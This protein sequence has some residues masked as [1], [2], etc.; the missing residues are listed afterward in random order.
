MSKGKVVCGSWPRQWTLTVIILCAIV[1][2]AI[3][4]ACAQ[5]AP[6][7]RVGITTYTTLWSLEGHGSKAPY[8]VI[9]MADRANTPSYGSLRIAEDQAT[10]PSPAN[11]ITRQGGP[12]ASANRTEKIESGPLVL[13][14]LLQPSAGV[15]GLADFRTDP[16]QTIPRS[17][18][19]ARA[20]VYSLLDDGPALGSFPYGYQANYL[21]SKQRL[22]NNESFTDEVVQAPRPLFELN[23]GSWRLPVMLSGAA[24]S[25]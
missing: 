22:A 10:N 7:T 9:G 8:L 16:R 3:G 11:T 2:W 6:P 20:K 25:R 12:A 18:D 4:G 1:W 21:P 17:P 15:R 23:F 5:D 13:S 19:P 24:V 14:S